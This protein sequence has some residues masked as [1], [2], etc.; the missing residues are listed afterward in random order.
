L[1]NQEKT[2][3]YTADVVLRLVTRLNEAHLNQDL[4]KSEI[5]MILNIRPSSVAVLST[6]I[7]DMEERFNDDEQ[8]AILDAISE[9][10]G[11]DEPAGGE[12]IRGDAAE[13][14]TS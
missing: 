4:A 13:N 5:L 9:A 12:E 14:G 1:V 3:Q 2:H 7:E 10:L 6:V 8:Q 11:H